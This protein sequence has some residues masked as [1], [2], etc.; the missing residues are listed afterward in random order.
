MIDSVDVKLA[1]RPA[2]ASNRWLSKDQPT[3]KTVETLKHDEAKRKNIPTAEYQS[4][5]SRA[6]RAR[7]ACLRAPQSRPRP[8]ARLARQG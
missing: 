7:S 6:S 1:R 8:A 4:V 3:A 5:M 2:Q